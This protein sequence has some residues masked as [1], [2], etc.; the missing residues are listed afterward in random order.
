MT[1][2]PAPEDYLV[3]AD[4]LSPAPRILPRLLDVL[5]DPASDVSQVIELI[6]YDPGLTSKVLR[7]SNS[8]F[9]G[10]PEPAGDVGEAVNLLGI[11]F[12]YQLTAA[13]CGASTFQSGAGGTSAL[14]WQHSVT[15]ALAAQLLA[16]DLGLDAGSLFTAALLHDIG[17]AVLAEQ[18]KENYWSMV[19]QTRSAPFELVA[20]EQQAFKLHHA[21][22][23]GRVL[24]H[25]KF[26]PSISASVWHHHAPMPGMPFERDTACVTLAD[27][28]AGA[29]NNRPT[30]AVELFPLTPGQ[31]RALS[32]FEFSPEDL[33]R[34][35][36]RTQENFE[37]V[38]AMCQVGL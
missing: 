22:L 6:S 29:I 3:I 19:E 25:W 12:V 26:P 38:N 5:S 27:A 17:K 32:V 8:A 7:A 13:A 1:N 18:W 20:L 24:A 2:T 33:K 9:V 34:Y 37:F 36:A 30:T 23:G 4:G 28:V 21:E 31:E 16:A 11:N 15:T 10:L 14:L 35:L